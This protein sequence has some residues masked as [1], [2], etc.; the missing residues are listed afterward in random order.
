MQPVLIVGLAALIVLYVVGASFIAWL[1]WVSGNPSRETAA[2]ASGRPTRRR[3]E[4]EI[5]S[6]PRQAHRIGSTGGAPVFRRERSCASSRPPRSLRRE[7]ADRL[8][9]LSR[10]IARPEG[11]ANASTTP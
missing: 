7:S 3:A 1:W 4:I 6:A 10:A 5:W 8:Q 9:L 2:A 11:P